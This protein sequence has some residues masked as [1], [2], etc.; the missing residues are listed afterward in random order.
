MK[1]YSQL[2]QDL[3]VL[4]RYPINNG[5]FVDV[6][7]ADGIIL[8]NT[9][10]LELNEWSGLGIDPL[11]KNYECRPNTKIYK[12]ALFSKPIQL[13]YLIADQ[14]SLSGIKQNINHHKKV[15]AD[16]NSK[17]IQLKCSTL[18]DVLQ[19]SQS[20]EFIHYLSLDTEGSEYE[21]LKTFPFEK[22][23]FGCITIEHNYVEPQRSMIQRFL[24]SKKYVLYKS[25]K[26]DD[27]YVKRA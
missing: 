5:Y 3:W 22:Y 4:E 1:S 26:W 20:P 12:T 15:L 24:K 19:L 8:S 21:I 6:G 13:E 14:Q 25:V 23:T 9:Y 27:W 16:K 7:F 11:A 2:A 17:V 10:L 18:Q